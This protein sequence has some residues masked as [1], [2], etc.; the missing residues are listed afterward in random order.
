MAE[1]KE[2]IESSIT[3]E[4]TAG[5]AIYPRGIHPEILSRTNSSMRRLVYVIDI[6]PQV[7]TP[8]F[9]VSGASKLELTGGVTTSN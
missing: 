4:I 3:A 7:V 1:I 6:R 5:L 2:Y 8:K 9:E